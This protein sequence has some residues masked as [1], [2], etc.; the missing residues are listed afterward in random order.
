LKA[1]SDNPIAISTLKTELEGKG[2]PL[3]KRTIQ[4]ALQALHNDGKVA[5]EGH[6]RKVTWKLKAKR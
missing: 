2:E 3:E 6:G 5:M 4:A 1:L